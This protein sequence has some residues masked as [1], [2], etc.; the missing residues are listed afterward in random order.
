MP[1]DRTQTNEHVAFMKYVKKERHLYGLPEFVYVTP[2]RAGFKNV[3][4][5]A[6]VALFDNSI[7]E[8]EVEDEDEGAD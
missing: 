1:V 6:S 2:S 3:S 8:D 4:R 7:D 5:T